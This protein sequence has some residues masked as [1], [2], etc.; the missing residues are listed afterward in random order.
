M[1]YDYIDTLPIDKQARQNEVE[2]ELIRTLFHKKNKTLLD[3]LIRESKEPLLVGLLFVA[4][5]IPY[6]DNVIKSLFPIT[7]NLDVVFLIVKTIIVMVIYW[8]L[9]HSV[10]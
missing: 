5:S 7:T 1:Y 3:T 9:K 6:S 8:L 10:F 4:F 2:L